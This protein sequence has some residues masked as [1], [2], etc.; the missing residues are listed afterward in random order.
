MWG[1]D[2]TTT[3]TRREG[4]AIVFVAVDHCNTEL[5]GVHAGKVGNRFEALEPIR[6]GVRRDSLVAMTRR[7]L[8][9]SR[10]RTFDTVE[11]L[12]LALLEFRETYNRKWLI[13]RHGFLTPQQA[14]ACCLLRT[15]PHDYSRSTAEG[16]GR[17]TW[18][19]SSSAVALRAPS[20]PTRKCS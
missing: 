9:V 4:T 11:E 17:A 12:R 14:H 20:R 18:A 5:V 2:A 16:T 1:T 6:Q 15:K 3:L 10:V 8:P 19:A 7:S 13:Q